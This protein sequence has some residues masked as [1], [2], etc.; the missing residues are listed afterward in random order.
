MTKVSDIRQFFKDGRPL[1]EQDLDIAEQF[2]AMR[3]AARVKEV[4][5][6]KIKAILKAKILDEREGTDKRIKALI[7][8]TDNAAAYLDTLGIGSEKSFSRNDPPTAT[9]S[10]ADKP[11]SLP[12]PTGRPPEIDLTLPPFLDRRAAP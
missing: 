7:E 4:D 5:W 8:K 6:S 9:Q 2:K 1:V 11:S 3:D 10:R 12:A